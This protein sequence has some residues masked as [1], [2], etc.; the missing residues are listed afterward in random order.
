MSMSGIVRGARSSLAALVA[1]A[2]LAAPV[3]ADDATMSLVSEVI[4]VPAPGEVVIDGKTDDWDLSAGVWSYNAPDIVDEYS[5]WTHLMWDAKGIYYLARVHDTD[6]MKN[7]TRGVDF[8]RGWQGDSIQLR[9]IFDDRTK[10]E[11]QMHITIYPS[12]PDQRPYMIVKH[13]GFKAKP[14]YDE[15]GPDRPDLAERFGPTMDSAGG[16]IAMAPW[17][18]G[19]G[20]NVEAF[21]PWTYLRLNGQPLKP[22]DSF[23]FGWETMWAKP[24]PP[25][26]EPDT[27]QQ[28]RL[29]DGVK[30]ASANRIFMFRARNAWGKATISATGRLDITD[31]QRQLREQRLAVFSDLS[32]A[33]AIPIEYALPEGDAPREVTIAI[34][35][36]AGNRVRN[37][38]GQYPRTGPKVTDWWDGLDDDGKPVSPGRYTAIIVDHEPIEVELLTSLYNAGTPPWRTATRNV[39]W[40]SDHGTATSVATHGDDVFVGFSIPESGVGMSC[41]RVGQGLQWSSKN[42]AVDIAVGDGYLYTFD[43]VAW[44]KR[45]LFSRLDITNGKVV[46]FE[47]NGGGQLPAV[48]INLPAAPDNRAALARALASSIAAGR[49]AVWL[50]IPEEAILKVHPE[51]GEILEK[52]PLGDIVSIRS[53]DRT[54]YAMRTDGAIWRMDDNLQPVEQV[55]KVQGVRQPGRFGVSPDAQRIGVCDLE[56]NQVFVFSRAGSTPVVIGNPLRDKDRPG[57]PFDRDDVLLPVA[58]AFDSAGHIWVPEGTDAIHR[59]SVWTADGKLHDEFW[60]STAYG[61]TM[62]WYFPH[63]AKRFIGR[64]VEFEVDYDVDLNVR[65]SNEK[66]LIYHPQLSHTSGVV[67]QYIDAQGRRHEFA[68]NA[69]GINGEAAMVIYRRDARGQFIP[70]AGLF[71]P[72]TKRWR[73]SHNFLS[74]LPQSDKPAGWIDRNGNARVDA[75]EIVP[76]VQFQPIYWSTGWVRP[77]M[78]IFTNTMHTYA[79]EG[80]NEHGVPV[81]DFS[82]P[83]A[84]PNPIRTVSNQG[85]TGSPI[86]DSAGNVTDGIAF[87]TIDGRRGRYPNRY[88]RHD[89]PS[90]QR[91]VLIAPFRTNGVVED[92]PGVGSV[93]MLQGD[94][95]EWYMLSF[96][97]LYITSLFQD[98]KTRVRM[99]ETLI[100]GESFGGHF[101]RVEGD[102]PLAGR[103]LLQTGHTSYRI[104]EVKKL[105]TIRRQELSLSVSAEDIRRGQEIA[106]AARS[107]SAEPPLVLAQVSSLPSQAPD[108]RAARDAALVN[109]QPFTLVTERGNASRWFKVSMLTDGRELAVIWQVA[110][111]SPWQNAADNFAK[112]FVGGD[113]VDLKLLSPANGPIRV[114]A[115]PLNGQPQ[116]IYW[117]QKADVKQNPQR[118]MV[119]NNPAN[120]RTFD[121][122]KVLDSAQVDVK[123]SDR[124]YSVLVRVPLAAIGLD[125][126]PQEIKGVAGVIFSD[127][128]GTDRQTRLYWHD[129]A[130][131]LVNDVPTE[132]SLDVDRFG[133][134]SVQPMK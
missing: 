64:G 92:V 91:G 44:E 110:D 6:P 11:H 61:A 114:L 94:R 79:I 101:W 12:T 122:V 28:H 96:D 134:I 125:P 128:A 24:T 20:Y 39:I 90:A 89:A 22:G 63:D 42:S 84:V 102:G 124:G 81:Y 31:Q 2:V 132:S 73:Q 62:G 46:P 103:V 86:M 59:T 105:E 126:L 23:V 117:Q 93:T 118:Y 100:G 58:V 1:G 60:G 108:P 77:D 35:D 19:K 66:P 37:L 52:R 8:A 130:T 111:D 40:G 55:L 41:Y 72:T 38:I 21:M 69:P 3:C 83:Q 27:G 109:G 25:D 4:A 26:A 29:A 17:D 120:A 129:K 112:A 85:S 71:Q 131:T 43:Y 88:G 107:Q 57:G 54:L 97:G 53:Q 115:A 127:P 95:G 45:F 68:I 98:L 116:A 99:D 113:A 50:H 104:F 13:G 56:T 75:D 15:T 123:T 76:N 51:T 67:R 78:T 49:D 119:P 70:A 65:K 5:V 106:A 36:S 47:R 121:V 133:V 9:V 7:A 33:G 48:Q 18:D 32:T 80:V 87:H 14:P 30:D 74:Q 82:R 16:R 34:E 10:D